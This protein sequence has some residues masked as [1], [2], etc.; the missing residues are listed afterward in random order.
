M[1]SD[2]DAKFWIKDIDQIQ[3][4]G[5][6]YVGSLQDIKNNGGSLP[7]SGDPGH[8]C[9]FDKYTSSSVAKDKL[10][11]PDGSTAEY[12]V[13]FDIADIKNNCRSAL[14]QGESNPDLFEFICRDVTAPVS[15]GA[16]G[17]TQFL[18]DGHSIPVKRVYRII[19]GVEE[20]VDTSLWQ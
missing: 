4:T 17:G 14:S 11:L 12:R 20:L 16:G 19:N 9:S 6:R 5:N 1:T 2:P 13:E 7:A 18:V 10:Q 3:G 8:Y 15:N